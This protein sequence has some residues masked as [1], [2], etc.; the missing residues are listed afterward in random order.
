MGNENSTA[1]HNYTGDGSSAGGFWGAVS[2]G[3]N[4]IPVVGHVKAV[5]HLIAKDGDGAI[6]AYTTATKCTI[7]AVL[8][9]NDQSS[10][11]PVGPSS[12]CMP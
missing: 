9:Y 2:R 7:D 1:H 12:D 11:L 10:D 5:V 6:E 4:T 8:A 3:L